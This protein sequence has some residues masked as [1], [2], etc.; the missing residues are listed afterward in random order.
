M[1]AASAHPPLLHAPA[2][3]NASTFQG[4]PQTKL[5]SPSHSHPQQH[6]TTG[7]GNG[8]QT[9]AA[10]A[11]TGTATAAG[12]QSTTTFDFTKRKRWADLLLHELSEAIVLVLSA[13]CRIWFCNRAV[14]ELLGWKDAELIDSDFAGL[15]AA[16][17]QMRFRSIFEQSKRSGE[18]FLCYSRLTSKGHFAY[19]LH[20]RAH[21]FANANAATSSTNAGMMPTPTPVSTTMMAGYGGGGGAGETGVAGMSNMPPP[22][23]PVGIDAPQEPLFEIK[24]RPHYIEDEHEPRCFFAVAK[25]Y[26]GASMAQCVF[27]LLSLPCLFLFLDRKSVV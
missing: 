6:L 10:A 19:P 1:A 25:P 3:P 8:T 16:D 24:V 13:D 12:A 14:S 4:P 11:A 2:H 7:S 23:P 5:K 20:Q 21:P 9:A 26:P 15:L 18:E 22:P 17:D 27:F